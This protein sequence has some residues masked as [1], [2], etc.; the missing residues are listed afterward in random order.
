MSKMTAAATQ[1]LLTAIR[2]SRPSIV[3]FSPAP[4]AL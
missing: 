4:S 3:A 2:S 1:A